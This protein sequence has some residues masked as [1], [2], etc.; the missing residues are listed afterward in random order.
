MPKGNTTL[1]ILSPG[2]P[3]DESD[4]T[5]LP[6]LQDF[7]R[8]INEQF[9]SLTIIVLALDY[10][11]SKTIY[12]WHNNEVIPL[13]GWK[14]RGFQKL[15]KWLLIWKRIKKINHHNNITGLLSLWC[16]EC[17]LLGNRFAKKNHLFHFCWIQGQD[18]RK[19]NKY[20]ARINPSPE[21]LIAL[22]DFGRNEFEKNH[23]IRPGQIIPLGIRPAVS[24]GEPTVRDIDV[25]GV[26]SLIPLKQYHLFIDAV[27]HLKKDLPDIKAVICGK[28]AEEINL[29]ALIA[30]YDLEK[31][32]MLTG[33]LAHE[34]I[35]RT[36]NRS[37]VFLHPS[38]YEGLSVVC[39]EALQA[40]C[41]VISLIQP[42]SYPIDHWSVA[43]TI[44]KMIVIA[45][46]ILHN[47][48]VTYTPVL[49]FTTRDSVKNIMH[50]FNYK[51][52]MIS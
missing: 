45:K 27:Y 36:M 19:E 40:G 8:E 35:I 7:I 25:L 10:P 17:A 52:P 15:Y 41:R 18:A 6:F 38:N 11:F 5:C 39:I 50:L 24:P 20:V 33:E 3:K 43:D 28:G 13:N 9:P 49:P 23:G 26:G 2:F 46:S 30:K 32:V 37:K 4:S 42:M 47:P 48:A 31:N 51:E 16:G 22:S 1:V 29:R 12:R 14:K 44:E 34:E 21:E